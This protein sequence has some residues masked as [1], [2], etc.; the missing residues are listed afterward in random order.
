MTLLDAQ[1]YDES[2]ARRRRNRI[3]IAVI[4]I[5]VLGYLGWMFRHWPQEHAV[6]H[7]FDALQSQNYEAAYGIWTHDPD[8]KQ[9]PGKYPNYPYNDFYRDWGPGGEW[10]VIKSHEVNGSVSPSGANGV[11]VDVTVN[12]RAEHARIWVDGADK[13]LGFS[14]Y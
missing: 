14:P 4:A 7:F 6:D 5:L 12:G 2:R 11:I 9:Y 8:W 3:I 1:Q 10:G 13:T